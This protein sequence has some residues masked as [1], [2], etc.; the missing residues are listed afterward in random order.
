MIGMTL[1]E[2][3]AKALRDRG[4][5]TLARAVEEEHAALVEIEQIADLSVGHHPLH[6]R[7]EVIRT[8]AR[9][10]TRG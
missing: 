1:A 6:A 7:L 9:R 5:H 8:N 4:L 10:L 3:A 2:E